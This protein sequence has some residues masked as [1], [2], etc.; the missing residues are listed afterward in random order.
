MVA[1]NY[2]N[3][4]CHGTTPS[5]FTSLYWKHELLF[6]VFPWNKLWTHPID[7]FISWSLRD[8]KSCNAGD[9]LSYRLLVAGA[10]P[11]AL[12][13]CLGLQPAFGQCAD[14]P[15]VCG[16]RGSPI[17]TSQIPYSVSDGTRHLTLT[18]S[19]KPMTDNFRCKVSSPTVRLMLLLT[20]QPWYY[21]NIFWIFFF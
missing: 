4:S 21:W 20:Q 11:N 1:V 17:G 16:T 18:V 6:N 14:I 15:E 10:I 19:I 12:P 8:V 3:L 2:V 5:G 13:L 7:L 9:T